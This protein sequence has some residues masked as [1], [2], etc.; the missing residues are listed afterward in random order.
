M[1]TPV[2]IRQRST[3]SVGLDRAFMTGSRGP[4]TDRFYIDYPQMNDGQKRSLKYLIKQVLTQ[5]P[6]EGRNK[7][8]YVFANGT[9][10]P[11]TEIYQELHLW[12]YH[13]G[14]WFFGMPVNPHYSSNNPGHT[15]AINLNANILGKTSS[16]CIHYVWES[17][18]SVRIVAFS[19]YHTPFP[20]ESDPTNTLLYQLIDALP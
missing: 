15:T 17:P 8:S 19:A 6:I 4:T 2:I 16:P 13:S 7:P 11:D 3:I 1:V 20:K 5:I 12:H 14:D 9:T 18:S 10:V